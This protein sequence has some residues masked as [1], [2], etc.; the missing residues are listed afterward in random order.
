MGLLAK[1]RNIH[2]AEID[3][4][5]KRTKD[6]LLISDV[7]FDSVKCDRSLLFR[8]LDQAMEL[9][10][11]VYI[12]GDLFDLMQGRWDPRGNY[13]ELRPEYKSIVYVDEVISDVAEKLTKYAPCIKLLGRGNHETNI[14]KRMMVSPL[15]RVAQILNQAGGQCAVGGYSGWVVFKTFTIQKNGV[16]IQTHI[17]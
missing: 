3:L 1:R 16:K 10:A 7:H 11:D 15:D 12:F 14:E 6:F 17:R 13:S 4:T 2:L 5:E 9:G 8:H